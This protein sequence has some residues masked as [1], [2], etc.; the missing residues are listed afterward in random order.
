MGPRSSPMENHP[1]RETT[2]RISRRTAA[3]TWS[4]V[5]EEGRSPDSGQKAGKIGWRR[6]FSLLGCSGPAIPLPGGRVAFVSNRDG[7]KAPRGA[8]ESLQLFVMD[9]DGTNVEKIGYLN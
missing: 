8:Q 4:L 2:R 7:F 6:K 1:S 5:L 3:P 9:D